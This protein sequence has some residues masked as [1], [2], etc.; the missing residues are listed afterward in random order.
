VSL[1]SAPFVISNQSLENV[2]LPSVILIGYDQSLENVS[3]PS[4][5]VASIFLDALRC[6]FRLPVVA[7]SSF[8]FAGGDVATCY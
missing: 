8:V 7:L 4:T 6:S 3:L 2:S 1:P 5:T